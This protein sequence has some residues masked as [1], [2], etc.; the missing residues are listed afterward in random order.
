MQMSEEKKG[1]FH[2]WP[3]FLDKSF[4]VLE[5][6]QRLYFLINLYPK[7]VEEFQQILIKEGLQPSANITYIF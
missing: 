3:F 7:V 1:I 6:V 2:F 4:L 5:I